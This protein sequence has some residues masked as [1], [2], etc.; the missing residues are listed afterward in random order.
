M[1]CQSCLARRRQLM[2][3]SKVI[4]AAIARGDIKGAVRAATLVGRHMA[5]RDEPQDATPLKNQSNP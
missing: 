4:K 3:R 1:P 2:E 5:P